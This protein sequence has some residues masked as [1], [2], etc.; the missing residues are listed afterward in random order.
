MAAFSRGCRRDFGGEGGLRGGHVNEDTSGGKGG[1]RAGG[2]MEEDGAE[3]GRVADDG[4]YDA[5]AGDDGMAFSSIGRVKNKILFVVT[6]L[7]L[8]TVL[9]F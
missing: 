5:G 1:K 6:L 3:V 7:K 2:W 8:D 9:R 4:E